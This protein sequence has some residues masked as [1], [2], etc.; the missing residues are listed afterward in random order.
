MMR[1]LVLFLLFFCVSSS[2]AQTAS[3]ETSISDAANYFNQISKEDQY[4]ISLKQF[5]ALSNSYPK[6]WLPKYYA[7]LVQVK[8]TLLSKGDMDAQADIAIDWIN[9]CKQL[10]INDEI[11]CAESL[12]L[13]TKMQVNPTFRWLSYKDRIYGSLQK[14]KTINPNNPRI[15]VL[16]ASLQ[17]HLPKLIGGGCNK[18]LPIAKQAE[19][20][21]KLEDGKRKY[22][23]SWGFTSI[24]EILTNCKY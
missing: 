15:Y 6:E 17:Y 7:A 19:K 8:I 9:K 21:L 4:A 24:K 23:P 5:I 11:L 10:Q 2:K 3:F 20:F 12:V 13:T 16:E 18:A 1:S 14:A 22:L